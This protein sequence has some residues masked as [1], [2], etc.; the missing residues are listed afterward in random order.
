VNLVA[1]RTPRGLGR[2]RGLLPLYWRFT[3]S[4]AGE[5]RHPYVAKFGI[6]TRMADRA[7]ARRLVDG[8]LE[9]L[10]T[11]LPAVMVT[12]PRAAGKTTTAA[13]HAATM[14]RLDRPAE[15]AI[16]RADPDVALGE[17]A[18]PIFL[19]EWQEVPSVLGAVKRAVDDDPRP[20]RFLLAGSVRADLDA[21]T[22]PGT[23]RLVRVAMYGMTV[24]EQRARIDGDLLIDQLARGEQVTPPPD[25]PDLRGYV[26][27][28]L[29]SGFPEPALHM[30]SRAR[31]RWLEGYVDELVTRDA[32]EAEPGRDP[33][34]LRRYLEA[35]ALNS[36]GNV[37]DETLLRAA[38]INRRTAAA[39]ERLLHNLFV[40]E[41]LPAWTSNRVRRLSLGAKR[42]LV[43]S[44]LI[45][46]VL[47]LDDRAVLLDASLLARVL[48]TFVVAQLR[49]ELAV[50]ET[51]P[52]LYHLREE[53]GRYE[54]DIVAELGGQA[55]IGFEVKADAAP[56]RHAARHLIWMRDRLGDRFVRG[57]VFHSGPAPFEVSERIS[58]LPICT[59]WS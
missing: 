35:Y 31:A 20:G 7:Y 16:F 59:L 53:H 36:A 45:A 33:A 41:T 1:L 6:V 5:N 51:R 42:Y 12:G 9:E 18:E 30:N 11:D 32:I 4:L 28:A 44:A 3:A 39:Y 10:L 27:L 58:A 37:S 24:S 21:T 2:R 8:L 55:V 49:S 47:R 43:D 34:R 56:D 29:T 25:P 15:A 48:D 26:E 22:W 46:A 40:A 17:R 23:G 38:G 54:V 14:V 57:V 13:R 19:D 52:R 50:S